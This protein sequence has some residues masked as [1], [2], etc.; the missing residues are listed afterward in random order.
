MH[1]VRRLL[2]PAA[3]YLAGLLVAFYPVLFSGFARTPGDLGDARLV[4]F[5]LEHDWRWLTGRAGHRD[6]WS[7]PVFYPA[8]HT[9]VE[10]AAPERF[11]RTSRLPGGSWAVLLPVA[12][13][14]QLF[15]SFYL[16]W[17][18]GLGLP[19]VAAWALAL[20]SCRPYLLAA[21]RRGWPALLAGAV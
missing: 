6:L 21:L 16:G 9:L 19:L 20:P 3:A 13:V 1:A 12:A 5:L 15:A 18:L 2:P 10:A 7:P 4:N 8:A 11:G 14:A 17:F